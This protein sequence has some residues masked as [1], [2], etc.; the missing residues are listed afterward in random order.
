[1]TDDIPEAWNPI[2]NAFISATEYAVEFNNV[3]Q[4]DNMDFIVH[5]GLLK[6]LFDGGNSMIDAFAIFAREMS[7]HI[8]AECGD[9]ATRIQFSSPRCNNCT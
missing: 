4:V 2:I 7:S 8:C 1:M 5:R 6:P 9:P 3:P